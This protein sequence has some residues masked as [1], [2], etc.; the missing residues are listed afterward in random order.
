[1]K[2][3]GKKRLISFGC[4]FTSGAELIDHE[5]LGISFDECNKMKHQWIADRKPMHKFE[6]YVSRVGKMTP[7]EYINV[8]SKRSYAAKLADKLG[9]EHVNYAVP[10]SAVDHMTLDLFRGHYTKKLNPKTDLI[11]LGVTTPHRYLSFFPEK[12]GVPVSRVM[13]DRD[14]IDSDRHYNDYKVMQTYLFALQN[15]KNFCIV[16][17]F[18]FYMQPVFPKELLFY[19]DPKSRHGNMFADMHF[20]WQ[21]L[22]TFKEIF[23]GILDLDYSIDPTISLFTAYNNQMHDLATPPLCGFKHPPEIAH[24][25]FAEELYDKIINT[26]N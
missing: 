7:E 25:L 6:D 17:N 22:P 2:L 18:D 19:N 24:V 11:L 15:F 4:S 3:E 13:S 10:G 5:I 16:N 8:S 23:Q 21:Y 20:D 1:M 9:L 14:F 26:K 12:T